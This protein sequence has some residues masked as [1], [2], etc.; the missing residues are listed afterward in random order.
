MFLLLPRELT[1]RPGEG[2][3]LFFHAN[4]GLTD[5]RWLMAVGGAHLHKKKLMLGN[6]YNKQHMCVKE[7]ES[8]INI[9]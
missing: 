7:I 1:G 9:I 8:S 2:A 3:R 6:I 5:C 4:L